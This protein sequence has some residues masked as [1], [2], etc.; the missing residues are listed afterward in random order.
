MDGKQLKIFT[1]SFEKTSTGARSQGDYE[2][3][4]KSFLRFAAADGWLN[5]LE[6]QYEGK[7]RM[8]V[9][10]FLRGFRVK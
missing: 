9:T 6:V 4:G 3:D 5:C 2:T 8:P 10:D 1:S 7:K